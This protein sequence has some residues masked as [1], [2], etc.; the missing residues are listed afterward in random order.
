L[1]VALS[2]S[3]VQTFQTLTPTSEKVNIHH[4]F[5]CSITG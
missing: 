3:V 4:A 1:C 2:L 5:D